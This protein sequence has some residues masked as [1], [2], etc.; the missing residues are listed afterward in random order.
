MQIVLSLK[1][2]STAQP[3]SLRQ[4]TPL[5]FQTEFTTQTNGNYTYLISHYYWLINPSGVLCL[6]SKIEMVTACGKLTFFTSPANYAKTQQSFKRCPLVAKNGHQLLWG[7]I[8]ISRCKKWLI[9]W[10]MKWAFTWY[11]SYQNRFS[12]SGVMRSGRWDEIV[13]LL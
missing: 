9:T 4:L 8:D 7:G 12:H 3:R 1:H 6:K 5:V 2:E 13:L 11:Q 10:S